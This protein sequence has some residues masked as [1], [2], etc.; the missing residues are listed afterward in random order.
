MRPAAVWALHW[1]GCARLKRRRN[2][3]RWANLRSFRRRNRVSAAKLPSRTFACDRA[4]SRGTLCKRGWNMN[5]IYLLAAACFLS[6]I[7]AIASAPPACAAQTLAVYR[8]SEKAIICPGDL[9]AKQGCVE[10]TGTSASAG[11]WPAMRRVAAVGTAIPGRP[12]CV[13]AVTKGV[14]SGSH[15]DIHFTGKGYYCP[16]SDTARYLLRFNAADAKRFDLPLHGVIRY[17]GKENSETFTAG[18][19][20]AN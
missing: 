17:Q 15:G 14:L 2:P 8:L 3:G 11:R 20:A 19:A 9:H 16:K 6:G 18:S 7:L 4:A 13:S 12:G 1:I 5:R 10:L